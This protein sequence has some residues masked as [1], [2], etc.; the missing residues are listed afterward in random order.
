MKK[1]LGLDLGNNGDLGNIYRLNAEQF[2]FDAE[3]IDFQVA[4]P[5]ESRTAFGETFYQFH[6]PSQIKLHKPSGVQKLTAFYGLHPTAYEQ[7]GMTDGVEISVRLE[8]MTGKDMLLFKRDLNPIETSSDRGEQLLDVELPKEEG[9]LFFEIN[10]KK[11]AAYDQFLIRN[12]S[13]TQM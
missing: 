11:S 3:L 6:A 9:T 13:V 8:T 2:G 7:G 1:I 4:N 5:I 12:I 10:P